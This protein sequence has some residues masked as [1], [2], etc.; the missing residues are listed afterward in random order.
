[1]NMK[2]VVINHPLRK[3][4][5]LKEEP[6]LE[7]KLERTALADYRKAHDQVWEMKTRFEK[8]HALVLLT[9]IQLHDLE[10]ERTD[11]ADT[12]VFYKETID[13]DNSNLIADL[14]VNVQIE[15]RDYHLQ[16]Q[17]L[18]RRMITFYDKIACLEKEYID[19]ADTYYS[20]EKPIDPLNFKVLDPVFYHHTDMAVDVGTLEKDLEDFL[21]KMTEV[22][23]QLDDYFQTYSDFYS[24]YST[25]LH[26][27]THLI[28]SAQILSP[29][30]RVED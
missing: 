8:E 19:I 26:K 29:L 12:L 11:L 18:H 9:I 27:T 21:A 23:H 7:G 3:I 16:V 28:K 1:M 24:A 15:L 17:H 2:S 22:Y 10:D 5:Y 14:E 20:Y 25:A 6:S 13:F 4:T 30:W